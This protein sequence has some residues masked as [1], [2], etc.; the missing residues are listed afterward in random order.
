MLRAGDFT[1]KRVLNGSITNMR[2]AFTRPFSINPH[3]I[4]SRGGANVPDTPVPGFSDPLL[5]FASGKVTTISFTLDID[6]EMTLR[7]FGIQ[8]ANAVHPERDRYS[9][10]I[11]SELEWYDSLRFPVDP[12]DPGVGNDAGLDRVI[13]SFGSYFPG[14]VCFVEDVEHEIIEF[15]PDLAPTKSKTS[16][17][18]KRIADVSRF[19]RMIWYAGG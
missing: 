17:T 2:T 12:S 11:S 5:C 3:T 19:S 16:I 9:Y 8:M 1:R 10:D 6:G 14:V 4:K 7:K 18:M 13:L 15:A